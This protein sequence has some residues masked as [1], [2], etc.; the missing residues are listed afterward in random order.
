MIY[1]IQTIYHVTETND[2]FRLLKIGHT[3]D[4]N[5]QTRYYQYKLHNPL[6][7]VLHVIPNAI[8]NNERKAH[9]TL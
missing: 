6:F 3:E 2:P 7:K 5:K 1:L 9:K 8:E 4:K